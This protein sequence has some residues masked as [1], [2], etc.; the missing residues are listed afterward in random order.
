MNAVAVFHRDH[1][2]YLAEVA[3]AWGAELPVFLGNPHWGPEEM[4]A[5]AQLM[6]AGTRVIGADF[7]PAGPAPANWP[8]SGR[9]HTMIPTGGTGGTVKFAVHDPASLAAAVR[10][11]C[12]FL[13]ARGLSP[14]LHGATLTPPWH[15]S[16]LMPF[17]RAALTGGR[18][19]VLDG[20]FPADAPL[21]TVKL[22]T[23]G[24]RIA[25]LVPA[26]LLRVLAHPAGEAWL[27][28]FHV[29]LLGGSAVPPACLREIRDRRLPVFLTYGMTETAAACAVCPPETIWKNQPPRGVPLP[30]VHFGLA[31]EILTVTTPALAQA[32]WPQ[33]ALTQNGY[34]TQDRAE[35][36]ADG[37]V[38]IL[39]RAD[40]VIVSGGEK[41]DPSRV[42]S[43]L[44]TAATT[45]VLGVPDPQWGERVVALVI[46]SAELE[47]ALRRLAER[48]E[49]AAR[50]KQ[51]I[52]VAE[53]PTDTRGKLD[54]IAA[55]RLFAA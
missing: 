36:G 35:L 23:D 8:A 20:R 14:T 47:P 37:T 9:S 55:K 41:V 51:Y 29:V 12:D 13:V 38:R 10:S 52:F 19:V 40:R 46:G 28:R 53:I 3:A 24:T 16:G 4:A 1:A 39:G 17:V 33:E 48:L 50:P 11:L 34:L 31:G 43:L 25:S 18:H 2:A 54:R 27:K 6:P 5:A 44:A 21:P 32:M 22:P 7:T 45:Y 26:Q 42:E 49:P 30:S 15:V